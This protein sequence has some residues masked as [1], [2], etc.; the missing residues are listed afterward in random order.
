MM[1]VLTIAIYILSDYARVYAQSDFGSTPD[2]HGAILRKDIETISSVRPHDE[3]G[4]VDELQIWIYI[5]GIDSIR[6][7]QQDF[8]MT[9]LISVAWNDWRL[10]HN[11]TRDLILI[12]TDVTK[13]WLPNVIFLDATVATISDVM[14][15]NRFVRISPTGDVEY[16]CRIKLTHFCP[17]NYVLFPFDV[18][19]CSVRLGTF[20]YF[21][22]EVRLTWA[23]LEDPIMMMKEVL[24]VTHY[25]EPQI[26]DHVAL[27]IPFSETGFA[28]I[29]FW[30]ENISSLC[31]TM[32]LQRERNYYVWGYMAPAA[33]LVILSWLSFWIDVTAVPARVSLGITT[34]LTFYTQSTSAN[35]LT[36]KLG[37][38]T[39]MDSWMAMCHTFILL[40]LVEYGIVHY[41]DVKGRKCRDE[42]LRKFKILRNDKSNRE[43]KDNFN[44]DG[45]NVPVHFQNIYSVDEF[46]KTLE[47][48]ELPNSPEEIAL[49]DAE[50]HASKKIHLAY[51]IDLACRI[52]FPTCFVVAGCI[53]FLF[54][55]LNTAV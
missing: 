31:F 51:K 40:A 12:G 54:T 14:N 4:P 8:S 30:I 21:D 37:Y 53:F 41:F 26:K 33:F 7:D 49:R 11:H 27:S 28:F 24:F 39:F 15:D 23:A 45:K 22:N 9:L 29:F 52:V 46:I 10:E 3:E 18:Q 19:L 20:G 6:D 17:M 35:H 2:H 50:Q 36:P 55:L 1:N 47:R 38:A 48:S 16:T 44:K 32:E 43:R 25:T 5:L 42:A 13:I 34:V